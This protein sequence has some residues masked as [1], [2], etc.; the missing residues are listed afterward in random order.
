MTPPASGPS[1]GEPD[2]IR[3]WPDD[4]AQPLAERLEGGALAARDPAGK[5]HAEADVAAMR[6]QVG[7]R[8]ERAAHRPESMS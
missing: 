6:D 1:S 2:R 5:N 8:A 7:K 4:L 3:L